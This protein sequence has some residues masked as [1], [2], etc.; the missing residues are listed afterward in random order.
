MNK[1]DTNITAITI[2]TRGS[3]LALV[4][5]N[6]VKDLLEKAW[7]NLTVDLKIITTSGDWKPSQGEAR[8]STQ[9]GGKG[10]FAKEIEEALLD[11]HVDIAVHSMKDMDSTLPEG[12]EIACILPREDPRDAFLFRDRDGELSK[13][14]IKNWPAGTTIGTASVRRGAML[15]S[16]NPHLKII[17]LRGNVGT[18]ISKLR[19]DL[20]GDFPEMDAT[21][22]AVAGLNRLDMVHEIDQ[23]IEP[24]TMLPAAAQGAVGIEILSSNRQ[25][26]DLLSPLNCPPTQMHIELERAVLG[27]LDGSCHTPIGA[28]VKTVGEG[29]IEIKSCLMSLDGKQALYDEDRVAIGSVQ[30]A[31]ELGKKIGQ[32]IK[33]KAPEALLRQHIG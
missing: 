25:L 3:P 9:D 22:L 2:G 23:I 20:I 19:G 4:Q 16:I 32:R 10:Q 27:A 11:G 13:M 8:L 26:N 14:P 24:E 18:R 28:Y 31:I 17:P 15:L 6:M 1:T 29:M 30:D 21:I 7:P 12:L 33:S 5:S